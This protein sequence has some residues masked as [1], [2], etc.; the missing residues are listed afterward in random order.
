MHVEELTCRELV[1]IVTDYLEG[2]MTPE[3]RSRFEEHLRVCEGCTVYLEQMRET[4]RLTGMLA[5]EQMAPEAREA[6]LEAF[7]NWK[8]S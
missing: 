3:Q 7:R 6:L 8:S 5:E 2:A 4:I 1:E